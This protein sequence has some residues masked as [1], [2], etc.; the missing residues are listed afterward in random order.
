MKKYTLLIPLFLLFSICFANE[1]RYLE[2]MHSY[3]LKE[4]LSLLKKC[5]QI[6]EFNDDA[7]NVAVQAMYFG[8]VDEDYHDLAYGSLSRAGGHW[9]HFDMGL[10][11][12]LYPKVE[13]IYMRKGISA[14][15]FWDADVNDNNQRGTLNTGYAFG[16]SYTYTNVP[17]AIMKAKKYYLSLFDSS[18]DVYLADPFPYEL[19]KNDKG[20]FEETFYDLNGDKIN[21]Y[22]SAD[23][24]VYTADLMMT[25]MKDLDKHHF[26]LRTYDSFKQELLTKIELTD[27]QWTSFTKLNPRIEYINYEIL[28]R[29]IHLLCDMSVPAHVHNDI[30]APYMNCTGY[31]IPLFSLNGTSVGYCD[32]YEGWNIENEDDTWFFHFNIADQ[33]G[34]LYDQIHN[35]NVRVNA[36]TAYNKLGHYLTLNMVDS[37]ID[38][39]YLEKLFW[40]VNQIADHFGSTDKTGDFN[41]IGE[42]DISYINGVKSVFSNSFSTAQTAVFDDATNEYQNILRYNKIQDVC[43]PVA[44]QAVANLL[45]WAA[46]KESLASVNITN[47][48]A[49]GYIRDMNGLCLSGA[50]VSFTTHGYPI[51]H[52]FTTTTDVSGHYN[53]AIYPGIYNISVV[54]DGYSNYSYYNA[55]TSYF[56]VDAVASNL[57][58]YNVNVPIIALLNSGQNNI[59]V[60][61][62]NGIT[63][64]QALNLVRTSNL[65]S[66]V[67]RI[68]GGTY[69]DLLDISGFESK[70]LEIIGYNATPI[71]NA[72]SYSI[73]NINND[74]AD[75]KLKFQNIHFQGFNASNTT[76]GVVSESPYTITPISF[77]ACKFENFNKGAINGNSNFEITSCEFLNNKDLGYT[78]NYEFGGAI[79]LQSFYEND[80]YNP[81]YEYLTIIKNNTFTGNIANKAGAL[82][83]SGNYK[84]EITG[85]RFE[86]NRLEYVSGTTNNYMYGRA[87]YLNACDKVT[88]KK[89]I[90]IDTADNVSISYGNDTI[91]S[92]DT[93][94]LYIINNTFKG[95]SEINA[96]LINRLTGNSSVY[97]KIINNIFK[98][99]ST[100]IYNSYPTGY[101]NIIHKY[102]FFSN[103]SYTMQGGIPQHSTEKVI[104]NL[105]LA[106]NT[107][108]PSWSSTG[109]SPCIDAGD[110]D[111]DGDNVM[112]NEDLADQD[113]D[114]T[115]S[116]VGAVDTFNHGQIRHNLISNTSGINWVAFPV[117][118]TITQNMNLAQGVLSNPNYET[119]INTNKLYE[120]YWYPLATSPIRKSV[121]FSTGIW[122]S[123]NEPINRFQGF[124][125]SMNSASPLE[126]SGQALP[127]DNSITL[128]Q[129]PVLTGDPNINE[130]NKY[131]WVGYYL[132]DSMSPWDAFGPVL[133]NIDVIKT[134]HWTTI[135]DANGNWNSQDQNDTKENAS[136][137]WVLNYG[138]LVMVHCNQQVSFILGDDGDPQNPSFRALAQ[139]FTYQEKSDYL[140]VL[141]NLENSKKSTNAEIGI[142]VNGLCKGAAVIE[143]SLVQINA[144]VIGDS[145]DWNTANVE[146]LINTPGKGMPEVYKNYAVYNYKTKTYSN[147]KLNFADMQFVHN[148]KLS[149]ANETLVS[150][151]TSIGSNYP[152]PFNPSTTINFSLK[153]EGL[154]KIDIYNIKGQKIK[155]LV[156]E[157]LKS[158]SHQVLWQGKDN[159]GKTCASG[160]YFCKMSA[161]GKNF[162][163]KM[164][165]VK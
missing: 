6:N 34:Y 75:F 160:I 23:D 37:S 163:K 147:S 61:P 132:K 114:G 112:W 97:A 20:D 91:F 4:G 44:I 165:M 92:A 9:N 12:L 78:N 101:H 72:N 76:T 45:N 126:V 11:D 40:N 135:K 66:S 69:S 158:G 73:V 58:N 150:I 55:N 107:Y 122:Q 104:A 130:E 139:T 2:E 21:V 111:L 7:T 98:D 27:E 26:L 46:D 42:S 88:I 67:I 143:D 18:P 118:N 113:N 123:L 19:I 136:T 49:Q 56:S 70:S 145:T 87:I 116:N 25:N 155:S 156:N 109:M 141:V 22:Y 133:D 96:L 94:T 129:N 138:D 82:Y 52:A 159:Y 29:I 144:Y 24:S 5:K 3:V 105:N 8:V 64:T 43:M 89:N 134:R 153:K 103:V 100:G 93:P 120:M 17:S 119:L 39:R 54:K 137:S 124:K 125:I 60:T 162:T 81:E 164:L 110:P 79:N 68:A 86:N 65:A 108:L 148:I 146:F 36:N 57:G 51:E 80:E 63:I 115:R 99:Y 84:Y 38:T 151:E 121:N 152:N 83:L 33:G 106:D 161:N 90:F 95:I 16:G 74:N 154:V 157:T 142:Y 1:S 77:I 117:V 30:H 59:L 14:T 131:N 48:M 41:L 102:N 10:T 47:Y 62:T 149:G 35:N 127:S 32:Y 53:V 15:H 13:K 128:Y 31:G 140:P 28:G 85:N 71:L 50:T